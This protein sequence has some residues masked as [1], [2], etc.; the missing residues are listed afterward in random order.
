[1]DPAILL[2]LMVEKRFEA[3]RQ[4]DL[5]RW[6]RGA[7]AEPMRQLAQNDLVKR[8]LRL[9]RRPQPCNP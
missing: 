3:R 7:S 1:M 2:M 4:E 9:I 6:G 5:P 8:I